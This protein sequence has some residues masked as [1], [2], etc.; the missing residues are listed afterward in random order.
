[1]QCYSL[2]IQAGIKGAQPT[3]FHCPPATQ[4]QHRL[5]APAFLFLLLPRTVASLSCTL[6]RQH[7]FNMSSKNLAKQGS[8]T[9][10]KKVTRA[11]SDDEDELENVNEVEDD[12]QQEESDASDDQMEQDDEEVLHFS[13]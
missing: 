4:G 9:V 6:Q 2:R 12:Q 5:C 7:R 11:S 10:E 3:V 1:M 8:K 13:L